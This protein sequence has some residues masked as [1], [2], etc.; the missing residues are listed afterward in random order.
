MFGMAKRNTCLR[1]EV[2]AGATTF[3]FDAYRAQTR[4]Q[5]SISVFQQVE[6]KA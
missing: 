3:V 2:I 5:Y 6:A 4:Y 1:T